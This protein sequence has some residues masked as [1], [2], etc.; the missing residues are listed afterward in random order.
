MTTAIVI[1][2]KGS[3]RKAKNALFVIVSSQLMRSGDGK[4]N[5][6]PRDDIHVIRVIGSCDGGKKWALFDI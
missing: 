4:L 6:G 3:S 2:D 1:L 5:P